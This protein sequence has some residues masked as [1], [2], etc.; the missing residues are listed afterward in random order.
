MLRIAHLIDDANPG[1]VTRYLDFLANDAGMGNLARH[2]IIQVPR[3]RPA[4]RRIDADIIVSHLTIS[5]RGLGGLM[6]LRALYPGT[7]LVHVEH[8]YSAGFVASNVPSPRRFHILLQ[9][10]YALFDRVVAVSKAQRDWLAMRDLVKPDALAMIHPCVD[11]SRFSAL[12]PPAGPVRRIGA[13]G[14]FN[15]QKG[16]DL[17]I[18]AFRNTPSDDLRLE[19]IGDG[20]ERDRLHQ[21]AAGDPR[22]LFSDF[23]PDPAAAMARCDAIAMPSRWEPFGLVA[24]EALTARRPLLVSSVDGLRDFTP[25]GAIRVP[26][27]TSACWSKTITRLAAAPIVGIAPPN[28]AETTRRGW[29]RLIAD[30]APATASSLARQ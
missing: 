22:I 11:L 21:I 24:L 3:T 5:W 7:P 29:Q 14:R 6:S 10:A 2:Q 27:L 1:G 26:T 25:L 18:T 30:L 28:A 19:L 13:I 12:K 17:L 15:V 20:P 16:F 8:S 4:A 9:W 23:T